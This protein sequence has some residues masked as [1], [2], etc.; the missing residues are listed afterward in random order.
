MMKLLLP[1]IAALT[2]I[3]QDG[4]NSEKV[5]K[6][7]YDRYSGKWYHT[8]TFV[9]KTENFK[10]DSL[11]KTST[12]YEA[13]MFPDKFRIDFGDLKEGNAV[14][15]SND[16]AYNFRGG[17]LKSTT[18]D[19]NDLTFLLGGLYFYPFDKAVAQVK[20]LHYDLTK[21]HTDTWN[22]KP[23]YVI[24]ANTN[25][26]KVNQL[27][28]DKEKMV[29]VR[30]IKYDDNRKEEGI[31]ED[32]QKFAGGWSEMKATFYI[33]DKLVQKEYYRECNANGDIDTKIFQP[34]E[35]GKVHWYKAGSMK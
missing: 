2:F 29:L 10:N 22:N 26:E 19:N 35:F 8:F 33:N 34:S 14:I 17:I 28:I 21:F 9:Q 30:F 6:Q 5:L 31:L 27:W 7:M 3:Q 23:V 25:D 32:Q 18:A 13:I 16:S 20:A 15:F 1:F 4:T 11:V 12:W 24:G